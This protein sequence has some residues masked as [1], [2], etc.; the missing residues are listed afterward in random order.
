M[1]H[2]EGCRSWTALTQTRKMEEI[3]KQREKAAEVT[4]VPQ[5][6]RRRKKRWRKVGG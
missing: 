3:V 6:W 2:P 5:R 1:T 4:R